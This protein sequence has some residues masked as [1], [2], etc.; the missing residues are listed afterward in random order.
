MIDLYVFIQE[1]DL[2]RIDL[3]WSSDVK[4]GKITSRI[5]A[6]KAHLTDIH[7]QKQTVNEYLFSNNETVGRVLK[8]VNT[9]CKDHQGGKCAGLGWIRGWAT[10]GADS[11][12]G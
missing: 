11:F 5:C 7:R 12:V 9:I 8:E 3:L 2:S 4:K 1:R 10:S 6:L